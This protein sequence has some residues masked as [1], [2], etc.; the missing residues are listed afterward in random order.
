MIGCLIIHGYTGGAYE[1]EPLRAYLSEKTDWKITVPIL[2]GHGEELQ[3]DEATH[4]IWLEE[5]RTALKKLQAECDEV[6][7]IGFSMGGMIA[8][9]LAATEGMDKLVLL[10]T[11]R[12]YLSFKYLS[13][14]IAE[15]IGDGF[16]GK[17][18]ENDK[19]LHYK[20][21]L[22]VVPF[23]ANIEFMR[24]VNR[25]KQYLKDVTTPVFIAQG[26][27]DGLVPYKAVYSLDEEIGSKHKEIVFFEQSDHLICLGDDSEVLNQMIYNFLTEQAVE[28]TEESTFSQ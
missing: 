19:Y 13:H 23:K 28:S 1:V 12:R 20:S 10:A 24:L 22:G 26:Q 9:Y 4:D 5:A 14:Y 18:K 11:A 27:K 2:M 25:T 6:Y 3:L 8:A 15:I 16:K 17:L 7:V 21:K